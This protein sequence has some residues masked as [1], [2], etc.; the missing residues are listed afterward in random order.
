MPNEEDFNMPRR[1][2]GQRTR[3]YARTHNRV[4]RHKK[5]FEWRPK[6]SNPYRKKEVAGPNWRLRLQLAVLVAVLTMLAG[7]TIYHPFFHISTIEVSGIERLNEQDV[8]DAI[9]GIIEGKRLGL[10]PSQ[11]FFFLRTKEIEQILIERFPLREVV[12]TATFPN[13]ISVALV[14]RISTVIYDDGESYSFLGLDGNIVE[15][16][17]KVGESEWT[18]EIEI[19]TTTLADGTVRSEEHVLSRTHTP[20]T[21]S[22]VAAV[23]DYPIVYNQNS[24]M[25]EGDAPVLDSAVLEGIVAWF[26]YLRTETDIPIRYIQLEND[27]GMGNIITTEGW[28]IA[29]DFDDDTSA[30]QLRMREVMRNIPRPNFQYIDVRFGDRVHWK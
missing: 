4:V 30:Q 29:V 19:T 24:T 6:K 14:E 27:F 16:I 28:R 1:R 17:R 26:T 10:F 18:E 13:T 23:G 12:V 9:A 22:L 25:P 21:A 8:T 7:V 3:N 20:D 5:D 15:I 2:Q 11:S